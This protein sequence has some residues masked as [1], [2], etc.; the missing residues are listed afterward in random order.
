[1]V[2]LVAVFGIGVQNLA[3]MTIGVEAGCALGLGR[4]LPTQDPHMPVLLRVE[5]VQAHPIVRVVL[6]GVSPREDS[7]TLAEEN[8][9]PSLGQPLLRSY[10]GVQPG[11][12]GGASTV[13]GDPR[14]WLRSHHQLVLSPAD[15]GELIQAV[16]VARH[17]PDTPDTQWWL[18]TDLTAD[19]IGIGAPACGDHVRVPGVQGVIVRLPFGSCT[20]PAQRVTP[21]PRLSCGPLSEVQP[22][23]GAP[24]TV[25]AGI[26]LIIDHEY[27]EA[28]TDPTDGWRI[29]VGARCEGQMLMEI[30][31]VC[32]PNGDFISAPSYRTPSGWQP[33]LL[34]PGRGSRPARCVNPARPETPSD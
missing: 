21:S 23:I 26:D 22:W 25:D 9:A 20:L 8:R 16:R 1:M 11:A 7:E 19:Q 32:E 2:S 13:P 34:E 30:A 15:I 4:C 3:A 5:G 28:A 18:A 27:A 17:W 12:G 14:E 33:S 31:D 10:Y 6:W 24:R 29:L